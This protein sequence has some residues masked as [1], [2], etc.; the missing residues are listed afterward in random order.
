M[1]NAAEYGTVFGELGQVDQLA[2]A[3]AQAQA[4]MQAA[5]KYSINPHL[6]SKYAD[7][8][9]LWEAIRGPLSKHGLSVAQV[10]D[11]HHSDNEVLVRT[12]LLHKSGQTLTSALRL[13]VPKRDPQGVGSAVTYARRYG[14]AAMVGA[15]ADV[16]DDGHAAMPKTGKPPTWPATPPAQ[17]QPPPATDA[18][19]KAIHTVAGQKGVD[20]KATAGKVVGR[21]IASGR[22][23]T[24][25]EASKVIEYLQKLP[26]TQGGT[27]NA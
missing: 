7:L 13:P 12:I 3:L 24:M 4:E 6:K 26:A 27:E 21:E 25:A 1:E 5:R 10:F 22:E 11:T 18:Q 23:L 14:L 20:A 17:Q 8:S 9:S 16:D 15:T 19:L 2:A